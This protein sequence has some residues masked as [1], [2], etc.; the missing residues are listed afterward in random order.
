MT[1]FAINITSD[2]VCPWCYIGKRRLDT[3]IELYKK[4]YPE[5]RTDTFS[6]NW[7]AFYLDP[8]APSKAVSWDER[9]VQRLASKLASSSEPGLATADADK[10]HQLQQVSQQLKT[11]LTSIGRQEGIE[12]SFRGLIGN[13]RSAHRAIAF[14]KMP[15]HL[16]PHLNR[17]D[18]EG[19]ETRTDIQ[20]RFVMALFKA[21]FE[22]SLDITSHEGI[23]DVGASVGL[24]REQMLAWLDS[25]R[26]G[27]EV[28][29]EDHTAKAQGINGVPRFTVQGVPVEGAVDVQELLGLFVKIKEE[30]AQTQVSTT[31]NV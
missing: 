14:S 8:A 6:I 10:Q 20:D 31:G 28:D 27:E 12:F 2:A 22:G 25:G 16:S 15:A 13:T 21:Y 1:Q 26:G 18:E 24:E 23:A 5:G 3:A 9:S 11:R 29:D 19:K 17:E 7:T 4:V 30:E